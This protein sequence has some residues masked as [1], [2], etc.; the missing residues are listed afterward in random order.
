MQS[1]LLGSAQYFG[2]D[3]HLLLCRKGIF[4]LREKW[5]E[6]GSG[7]EY[8]S[9]VEAFTQPPDPLANTSHVREVD[10]QWLQLHPPFSLS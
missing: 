6:S 5:T 9:D 10:S 1:H 2:D 7:L 8:H 4:D 3:I